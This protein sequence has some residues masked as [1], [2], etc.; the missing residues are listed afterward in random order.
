M[1]PFFNN[2][3]VSVIIP[4]Y[5]R[6]VDL[7]VLLDCLI[8][9]TF[10]PIEVIVVD[11]TPLEDRPTGF[12]DQ[13]KDILPIKVI[14]L[15]NPS[16]TISRNT[17]AKIAKGEILCFFDDKILADEKLV[18]NHLQVMEEENVDVV[19]GAIYHPAR[20]KELPK[21]FNWLH[22]LKV[23][24]PVNI[25]IISANS[26]WHG[27]TIGVNSANFSIKR[28]IFFS[29]DG[30]DEIIDFAFED[31]EF[32]YRLFRSGAKVYFSPK[33]VAKNKR[34]YYG[35]GHHKK[36]SFWGRVFR[37]IPHPNYLYIHMKHFP[38]WTTKQLILQILFEVYWPSTYWL[39]YPWN[40]VL[41]PIRLLRAFRISRKML[42]RYCKTISDN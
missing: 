31:Y 29:I 17:G 22:Q 37:P 36:L 10:K 26:Q 40:L 34:V 27:M 39:R 1:K 24:D 28:E 42:I 12:Y 5:Y 20:H 33:P 14:N 25:F 6:Y 15:E 32:S 30:F 7:P 41:T 19:A 18:E 8:R 35:G 23:L 4:T 16:S 13:Y 2:Y 11:Q 3:Q 38:G 9:Q 21:T